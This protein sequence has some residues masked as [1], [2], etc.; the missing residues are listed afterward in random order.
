MIGILHERGNEAGSID[1]DRLL[2][3]GRLADQVSLVV[4][5][6]RLRAKQEEMLIRLR[7]LDELKSDF[8]AITSHEL[9]TPLTAV[10]GFVDA[11]RRRHAELSVEEVQEYL[12]II[13]VQT[14]RLIRL[15][16]D[17]LL[18]SRIEAGKLTFMPHPV[19]TDNLLTEACHG[20]GELGAR[21]E[22]LVEPGAPSELVVDGQRLIQVLTNLLMN[23]I[24]FSPP[25][26]MV[27]LRV[28]S[29]SPGTVTFAAIRTGPRNRA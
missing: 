18:I 24:K 25:A 28:E 17:L 23:A 16:E 10:R 21:V 7:E 8:V 1:R 12:T 9:R 4:Q 27:Q 14:D 13:H 11:L 5:A 22:T 15:V 6:A 19:N 29:R 26:T 2:L 3:L 20:L